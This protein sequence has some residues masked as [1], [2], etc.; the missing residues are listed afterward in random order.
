MNEKLKNEG[1][2]TLR[3]E[4][5]AETIHPLIDSILEQNLS[6]SVPLLRLYIDSPGGSVDQGFALI[7]IMR[8]SSIP[9]ATAGM[10][11][12]A[13]M[14]LLILMAGKSGKRTLM[15]NCSIL[16]HRFS[17]FT[18]GTHADLLAARVQ[19]DLIHDRILS[20]Y[21]TCTGITSAKK[22][23]LNYFQRTTAG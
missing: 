15:P 8:W 9:I 4:V 21:Q 16:S 3:G 1:V 18:F 13:S 5:S 11:I 20:H 22:S 6:K 19:Q 12:V 17:T 2:L 23:R 10:G 7:D 14:G